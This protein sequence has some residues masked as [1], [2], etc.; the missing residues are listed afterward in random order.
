M[1]HDIIEAV[2]YCRKNDRETIITKDFRE[3]DSWYYTCLTPLDA[4]SNSKTSSL[5]DHR[6]RSR[7]YKVSGG[8]LSKRAQGLP[9]L[10]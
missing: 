7:E 8:L 10:A 6:Q 3:Q 5:L 9:H 4:S 2:D 1:P